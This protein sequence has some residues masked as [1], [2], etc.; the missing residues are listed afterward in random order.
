MKVVW[1]P[2]AEERLVAVITKMRHERTG[3]GWRWLQGLLAII[4]SLPATALRGFGVPELPGRSCIGQVYV[5]PCRVVYRIDESRIVILT[6]RSARKPLHDHKR[7][8][9]HDGE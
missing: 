3:A 2:V 6:I 7:D 4:R 5:A 9:D 8:G 1:S